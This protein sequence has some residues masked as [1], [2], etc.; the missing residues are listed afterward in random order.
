MYGLWPAY[1]DTN[2]VVLINK[3]G[4]KKE[5]A[6]FHFLR[7]QAK[8]KEGT[9]H[10]CLADFVAG[11]SSGVQDSIGAFAVTAGDHVEVMAKDFEND[12]DDYSSILVK[13]VGD[14]IA[15]AFAE[16]LHEYVRKKQYGINET[17]TNQEL[18]DEKYQGIRPA[19]GYPSCP[20]H[21]EKQ[22]IWDLMDA[23]KNIGA[24]LTENFAMNPPSSVSGFYFLHPEA[25]YFHV[26]KLDLTQVGDYAKRKGVEKEH[27]EKWLSPNLGY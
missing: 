13:A 4:D 10:Y 6:R 19:I 23:E 1:R 24:T 20:D 12:N 25:R 27:I 11:D 17:F 2:D 9:P 7:Q 14:R 22:T 21:T 18:I 16:K 15:E 3:I 8:K 26:G 5:L